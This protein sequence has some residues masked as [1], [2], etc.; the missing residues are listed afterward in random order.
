MVPCIKVL[1]Y[2][3]LSDWV[4]ILLPKHTDVELGITREHYHIDW[5]FV[6]KWRFEHIINCRKQIGDPDGVHMGFILGE[7]ATTE[8]FDKPV[9][10]RMQCKRQ[11]GVFPNLANVPQQVEKSCV[12][13][14][15]KDNMI[16]PHR[17]IDL[18]GLEPDNE[19]NIVCPGH[20][21]KFNLQSGEIVHRRLTETT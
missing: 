10:K 2:S 4:P 7:E 17:G 20:G 21:L 12:G 6:G 9:M 14:T 5:R 15:L 8:A 18:S 13:K 16:C 3:G 1:Y 19:G 11:H